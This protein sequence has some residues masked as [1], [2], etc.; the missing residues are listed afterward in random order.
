VTV[1][2]ITLDGL[3][4]SGKGTYSQMMAKALG[5]HYLDS[6]ALFRAVAWAILHHET[7]YESEVQLRALLESLT[8]DMTATLRRVISM[9]PVMGVI[10]QLIFALK[11]WVP[12][13]L[14]VQKYS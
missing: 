11:L 8:I 7:V 2:V 1:P 12:W 9:C 3:S 4:G 14:N 13:H 6:G 5:W 10:L